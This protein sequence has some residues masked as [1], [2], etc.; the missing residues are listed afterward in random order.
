VVRVL[1]SDPAVF[2]QLRSGWSQSGRVLAHEPTHALIDCLQDAA[3]AGRI[4]PDV[5]LRSHGE[6]MA[7][8]LIGTISQWT[9]GLLMTGRSESGHA[10]WST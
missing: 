1:R 5:N 10:R 8:G 2:R 6:V 7:A 3:D 4:K 9:A